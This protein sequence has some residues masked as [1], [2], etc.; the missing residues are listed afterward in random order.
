MQKWLDDNGVLMCSSYNVGKS[1][2]AEKF[3]RTLKG[4]SNKK[5]APNN[6]KSYLS[7]LNKLVDEYNNSYYYSIG[8]KPVDADYSALTKEIAKNPK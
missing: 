5:M 3:I 1:A 7:Y 2:V 8:K 4:K 6:K